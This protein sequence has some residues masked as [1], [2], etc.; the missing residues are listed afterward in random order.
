MAEDITSNIS[1]TTYDGNAILATDYGTSGTGV[2]AAH[3]QL[4][5][6]AW[7]SDTITKRVSETYPLPTYLY[8]TSGSASIG[9]TGTV[10]GTG[11][12]FPV[13]NITNTYLVVGGPAA[14]YSY[15]YNSLPITGNIQGITNGILFGVTGTL[16]IANNLN[17][18][19][20]TNGLL[21]GVTGGLV[22][23]KN[24]DSVTVYGN[25]GISGGLALSA[26]TNS[27]AVWGSDLGTKVL[28]R[29]YA[30]DGTTLGYSGNALNVNIVGAGI[31]ATVSVNPVIGV[32]NGYGLPL[33][34]CGSG[35]TTDAA[36]I[37]QGRLSGGVLE[38][39]AT[40]AIP[41]TVSGT[42][43][44]DD[45]DIISSLESVDKPLIG[46]LVSIKTNT[47]Y[48]STI[49]DKLNTGIIQSKVTEIV[50]PTK[51]V[52]GSKA[53]TSTAAALTSSTTIKVGVHIK[54][55]LTNTDTIYIGSSTLLT[56]PGDGYPLEPGESIFIEID[57]PNKIYA[58]CP[59]N[60]Q[61]VTY[62]AS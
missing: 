46:N 49:N 40:T 14:G 32:T 59:V 43:T 33:K 22:L 62:I 57:N 7:G 47:G 42:V 13:K 8:G 34:I 5:K 30:S 56:S 3:V 6:L 28:T 23:N 27:I 55:P 4:A 41:A 29:I 60:A 54:S 61:T 53:L 25:V 18:Q 35:V 15:A 26:G 17:I 10:T 45:A 11:G 16:F 20:I 48:V 50:R 12:A 24:T 21:V 31:T 19:G 52:N 39:G 9:I 37:V 44:I 51:F 58:R 2:S 38:V 36:V 1:I